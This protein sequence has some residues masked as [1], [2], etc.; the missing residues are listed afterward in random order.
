MDDAEPASP[1]KL[2]R[3]AALIVA[4]E[5]LR[6]SVADLNA[7][8]ADNATQFSGR[9]A[10][11][12]S[13]SDSTT[14]SRDLSEETRRLQLSEI[15]ER[16]RRANED[17]ILA[18]E[19]PGGDRQTQGGG[20]MAMLAGKFAAVLGPLQF[21]GQIL[22][23]NASGFQILTQSMSLLAAV[24]A[25]VFLPIVLAVAGALLDLSEDV[26]NKLLPGLREWSRII[27]STVVPVLGELVSM[28]NAVIDTLADWMLAVANFIRDIPQMIRDLR[29]GLN[30][31]RPGA[32]GEKKETS[33][34]EDA[35]DVALGFL[36]P[37]G[38]GKRAFDL[39]GG[40]EPDAPKLLAGGAFKAPAEAEGAAGAGGRRGLDDAIASFRLSLGPKASFSGLADIGKQAQLAGLNGDPIQARLLAAMLRTADAVEGAR[41]D[42]RGARGA[43]PVALPRGEVD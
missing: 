23:S 31:F 22:Q 37:S 6:T 13:K 32:D 10:P 11:D 15:A 14:T 9:Q 27:F 34:T 26:Q 12:L 18:R 5:L 43:G 38:I 41:A 19:K 20:A 16:G 30:P 21:F 39:F 28:F 1:V 8:L 29:D 33:A 40:S 7:S 36:D 17:R 2:D 42:T 3:D 24:L 4:L 35:V 25:P